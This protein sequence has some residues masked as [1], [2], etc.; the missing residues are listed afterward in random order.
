MAS[1]FTHGH[2]SV[3]LPTDGNVHGWTWFYFVNEQVLRYLNL[4]V[5]RDYDTVPL[6]LFLGLILVWLMPWSAFLPAALGRALPL[7]SSQYRS[8]FRTLSLTPAERTRLLLILWAVL[9]LLFFTF[10]TRQ[11][12]YVLPALPPM[13]LLLAGYL[14]EADFSPA[15]RK[16][17]AVLATLGLLAAGACVYLLLHTRAPAPGTDLASLLRQNPGDY[18]LSFGHFLDLNAQAMG[19]FRLPLALTAIAFGLG[20]PL[21]WLLRVRQNAKAGTL[22]TAAAAFLFLAAAHMGL[23][24]FSP[25]LTSAQLAAVI[26]PQLQPGDMIAI[27]GEYESGSTLGFYLRRNDLHLV[28]GRSSNLWYG[29][30]FP[31]APRIFETPA[32]LASKWP[33]PQRIFLWQDPSDQDRP[34]LHLP[35]PVYIIASSG[36]KQILSNRPAR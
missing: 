19:M 9:P 13:I 33:G 36:G 2:F 7:A 14:A 27:H 10:S 28:E 22:T 20:L 15:G 1:S 16:A 31:D 8:R 4:R 17:S 5:P 30:F 34:V 21:A 3:P 24:T 12:Y 32:S 25:T 29:S 6:W 23:V 18:A 11:E 26:A 35:G